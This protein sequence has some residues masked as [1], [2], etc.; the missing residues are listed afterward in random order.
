MAVLEASVNNY[1]N[2]MET[3]KQNFAARVVEEM[4]RIKLATNAL[5][6]ESKVKFQEGEDKLQALHSKTYEAFEKLE[7]KLADYDLGGGPQGERKEKEH[8]YIP[9]KN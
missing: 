5:F 3:Q 7:K 9:T 2:L 1:A 8:Y 6:N 4:D